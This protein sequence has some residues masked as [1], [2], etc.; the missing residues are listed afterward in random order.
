MKRR[1]TNLNDPRCWQWI[2]APDIDHGAVT[3]PILPTPDDRHQRGRDPRRP[4]S[5]PYGDDARR[6]Y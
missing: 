1:Y 3:P 4:L 5:D 2:H 6:E